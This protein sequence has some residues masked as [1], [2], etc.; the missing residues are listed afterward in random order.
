MFVPA[1]KNKY[2]N[3]IGHRCGSLKKSYGIQFTCMLDLENVSVSVSALD[4]KSKV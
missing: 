3:W 4:P 1:V 2:M